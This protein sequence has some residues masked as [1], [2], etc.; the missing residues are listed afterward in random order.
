MY[1][2]VALNAYMVDCFRKQGASVT[3]CNNF[4]RYILAGIGSLISTPINNALGPGP[5]FTLCGGLMVLFSINLIIV[6]KYT[7]KWAAYRESRAV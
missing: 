6:R 1:P 3:A 5:L 7:K 4:A 2:N